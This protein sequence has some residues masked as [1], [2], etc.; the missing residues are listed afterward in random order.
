M[1]HRPAAHDATH[2]F[3]PDAARRI[4]NM[5]RRG[6][7]TDPAFVVDDWFA[8]RYGWPLTPAQ[9]RIR[10]VFLRQVMAELAP[11]GEA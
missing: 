6:D 7:E 8:A 9:A 5:I 11:R 10:D 4:A 1:D 2:P 3:T